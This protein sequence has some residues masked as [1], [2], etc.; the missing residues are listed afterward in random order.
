MSAVVTSRSSSGGLYLIPSWIRK[1]IVLLSS[2]ISGSSSAR[3]GAGS[4]VASG[5]QLTSWR[6]MP[7]S[8]V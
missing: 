5:G 7:K 3:S 6:N 2:E 4:S 8:I 1:V